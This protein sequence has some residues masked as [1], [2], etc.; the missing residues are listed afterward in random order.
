[1]SDI[2]REVDEEVRREQLQQLW[3]RYGTYLLILAVLIV[4]SVAGWRGYE[5]WAAK[6]AAE[7]GS[8]FE[9][10]AAL[11]QEGK[12]AEAEQAFGKI[13]TD[14]SSGYRQLARMR[15][16]GE[17]SNRGCRSIARPMRTCA[18]GWSR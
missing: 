18:A 5:Y 15:E 4:A 16:A 1:V 3:G 9:S 7:A 17:M 6:K 11:S 13:A 10:A 14:S 2:F 8:A 12:H